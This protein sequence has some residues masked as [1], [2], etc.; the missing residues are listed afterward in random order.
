MSARSEVE[1]L[2][3]AA[4]AELQSNPIQQINALSGDAETYNTNQ[5]FSRLN[6]VHQA[7][8]VLADKIDAK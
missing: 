6:A 4:D 3:A 7:L 8:L 5:V 1:A 2:I